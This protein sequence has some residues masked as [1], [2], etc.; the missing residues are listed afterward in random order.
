[1]WTGSARTIRVFSALVTNNPHARH[2]S[3]FHSGLPESAWARRES[4]R[5]FMPVQTRFKDNDVY[6]HI[7]H[8]E[9]D[10]LVHSPLT[11]YLGHYCGIQWDPN[12]LSSSGGG[13]GGTRVVVAAS[14]KNYLAR[15]AYPE[16]YLAGLA[17]DRV[18][19]DGGSSVQIELNA[20]IRKKCAKL[21]FLASGGD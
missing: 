6:G 3:T 5:W 2:S 20:L 14:A 8:S 11:R 1:M 19:R 12:D 21:T 15:C 13:G 9:Y 18:G 17:V 4:Y 10:E 7:V 16:L